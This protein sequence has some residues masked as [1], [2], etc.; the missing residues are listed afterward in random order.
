MI[1]PEQFLA[2][3]GAESIPEP[4]TVLFCGAALAGLSLRRRRRASD[5]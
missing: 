5:G 3:P 4:A 2:V 1:D